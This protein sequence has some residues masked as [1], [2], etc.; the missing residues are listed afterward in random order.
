MCKNLGQ[1]CYQ[2]HIFQFLYKYK[3]CYRCDK[4]VYKTFVH[5]PI[6]NKC[7]YKH[8]FNNHYGS[9]FSNYNINKYNKRYTI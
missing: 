3:H 2:R 5:C 6:C 9:C 8:L 1:R 4:C 7:I